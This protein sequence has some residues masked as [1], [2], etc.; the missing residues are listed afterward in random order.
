M[1]RK[2]KEHEI[3]DLT[4]PEVIELDSDVEEV[5]DEG[6]LPGN[7]SRADGTAQA[8]K[9]RKKRRKKAARVTADAS[10]EGEGDGSCS[11]ETSRPA[12]R[13]SPPAPDIVMHLDT[14]DAPA[15]TQDTKSPEEARQKTLEDR[16]GE[17]SRRARKEDRDGRRDRREED[18]RRE[19]GG[20]RDE[21]VK[22]RDRKGRREKERE[23]DRDRR[24][25]RSPRHKHER[26]RERGRDRTQRRSR[27]RERG[28]DKD[29]D[30]DNHGK[31]DGTDSL[32]FVDVTPVD[33]P[34]ALKLLPPV[35]PP[36]S[37]ATTGHQISTD[38]EPPDGLL[39]PEHVSLVAEGEVTD[40]TPLKLPT[41]DGS[42]DDDDYIDY[43]E[44]DDDRKVREVYSIPA[45]SSHHI[46]Q[47]GMIRYWELE[48]LEAEEA[49]ASK[50][51]RFVCKKCGAEGDHKTYECTVLIVSPLVHLASR[52]MSKHLPVFNM[53][54]A[55]RTSNAKLSD[56]QSLLHLWDERT[57][58]QGIQIRLYD[59]VWTI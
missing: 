56:Q 54:R 33:V 5:Q 4:E 16:L 40:L 7:A 39:L 8:K 1:A 20:H 47:G 50:P 45:K 57:H 46:F 15:Q 21:R 35:A 25:S 38:T 22:D 36:S 10:A 3:I 18:E 51:T 27:S 12:S 44:Y 11:A 32:F 6:A 13:N 24:R 48:K 17:P 52:K 30:K 9:K 59:F 28:R 49:K 34:A 23:R 55:Q 14:R 53:W 58:Q 31:D 43:L 29:K 26:E 19:L 2:D 42:D 41:P 37:S